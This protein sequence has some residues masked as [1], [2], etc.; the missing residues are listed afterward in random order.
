VAQRVVSAA[1]NNQKCFWRHCF[2]RRHCH[3]GFPR[4]RADNHFFGFGPHQFSRQKKTHT[5]IAQSGNE[6]IWQSPTYALGL[7]N[8]PLSFQIDGFIFPKWAL[9]FKCRALLLF[10]CIQVFYPHAET[11]I[12]R[13]TTLGPEIELKSPRAI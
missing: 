13:I 10:N 1:C 6:F 12:D 8:H 4:A 5:P 2:D 7:T 3:V 11:P 9:I